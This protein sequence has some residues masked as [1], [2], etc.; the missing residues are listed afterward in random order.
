LTGRAYKP[1]PQGQRAADTMAK[2]LGTVLLVKG[3]TDWITDSRRSKANDIHHEWMTAGGTG[4]VLAGVTAGLLSRN[5]D[6]WRVACAAA[7]LNGAAGKEAFTRI[8]WGVRA[9]DLVESLPTVLQ[10][11]SPVV[12]GDFRTY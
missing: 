2:K 4:D 1:G 12:G 6:A 10:D 8:G 11:W 9:T 3:A 5:D 7:F